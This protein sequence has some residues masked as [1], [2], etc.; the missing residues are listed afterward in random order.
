LGI[1][2]T[3]G[4]TTHVTLI[5]Q[6]KK[7]FVLFCL[8]PKDLPNHDTP[9]FGTVQKPSRW[10][11]QLSGFLMFK[12]VVQEYLNIEQFCPRE[13]N[14]MKIIFLEEIGVLFESP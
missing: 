2:F 12:F 13:F 8:S 11:H 3:L 1:K 5:Y 7:K 6:V 10:L 4:L 9:T 14:K